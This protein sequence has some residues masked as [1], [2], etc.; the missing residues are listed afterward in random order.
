MRLYIDSAN[1]EE[2]AHLIEYYPIAGVTTNPSII[3]Q[4]Q[5]PYLELFKEIR[6]VIGGERELFIQVIGECAEEIV[7]EAKFISK[8]IQGNVVIKIPVTEEAIKATKILVSDGIA[9]LGTAIYTPFQALMAAKAGAK[10][11]A[12]YVNR[13]D[14]L[15]G[16][17]TKVVAEIAQL[18]SNY[19]VATEILAASFKNVQQ[20]HD[21]CLAGAHTVTV[22]PQLI[23]TFV[24]FPATVNDIAAF[25][26]Q[27]QQAYGKDKSTLINS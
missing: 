8:Q 26:K 20:I 12:P 14:N 2:I 10:Y 25:K 17:G 15:T 3:V 27:W 22:A 9:V 13:I 23:S 1:V 4:E 6:E 11:V 24:S 7:A 18:F 5:R 21:V 19:E 16:N